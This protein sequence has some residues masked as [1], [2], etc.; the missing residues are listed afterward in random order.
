MAP[1]KDQAHPAEK[2]WVMGTY[3]KGSVGNRERCLKCLG[4]SETPLWSGGK[5]ALGPMDLVRGT[6]WHSGFAVLRECNATPGTS[7]Q[8]PCC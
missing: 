1:E 6:D 4:V 3:Y 8:A 5:G 2:L 7:L